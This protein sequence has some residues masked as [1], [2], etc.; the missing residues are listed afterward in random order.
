MKIQIQTSKNDI[1]AVKGLIYTLV[2]LGGF[3]LH[4]V[5]GI[6]FL[7]FF[8][9]MYELISDKKME[10]STNGKVYFY[11]FCLISI[12]IGLLVLLVAVYK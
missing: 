7:A 6:A 11:T 9:F 5:L 10:S 8:V 12:T 3:Y 1:A 4:P 2:V